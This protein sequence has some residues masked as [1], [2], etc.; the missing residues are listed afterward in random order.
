M[1]W[2]RHEALNFTLEKE[3]NDEF[4]LK[5]LTKL[6]YFFMLIKFIYVNDIPG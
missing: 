4:A 5:F 2:I 1:F 3:K 6:M